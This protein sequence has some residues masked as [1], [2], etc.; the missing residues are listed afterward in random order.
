MAN[1]KFF[2]AA[3]EVTGSCHMLESTSFG[4]VLLDCGMHQGGGSVGRLQQ[5]SFM[6]DPHT[7]D[8]VILSHAHLDH[9]GMLPKLV[10]KGFSGPIYCADATAEL[11]EVMLL[12]SV[13]IYMSDLERENR[14]LAR[15]GK[16]LLE[17]EY[18]EEHVIQTL[19]LCQ[20]KNY[21]QPFN[22]TDNA[23]VT[24]YDAGHILG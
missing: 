9:S 18:T 22:L 23:K 6:F 4:R 16:T 13:N 21:L 7:I 11:L 8:A 24:F 20:S 2:G 10:S 17:P 15:K 3:Q 14:R 5:E 19:S 12:D 1:I